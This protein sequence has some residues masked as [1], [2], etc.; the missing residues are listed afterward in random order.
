MTKITVVNDTGHDI[1]AG[2]AITL[3][4]SMTCG[5]VSAIV[6]ANLVTMYNQGAT[7][8]SATVTDGPEVTAT[9][10]SGDY[11]YLQSENSIKYGQDMH[12]YDI[13]V[14]D[15]ILKGEVVRP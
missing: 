9:Y 7:T 14:L 13:L 12:P 1:S 2:T 5:P 3:D 15:V 6:D 4:E 8:T 11:V 10:A